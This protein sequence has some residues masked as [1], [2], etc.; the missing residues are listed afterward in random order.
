[1][2]ADKLSTGGASPSA[3]S[4]KRG[5]EKRKSPLTPYREKG[6]EKGKRENL[7]LIML[8]DTDAEVSE[9]VSVKGLSSAGKDIFSGAAYDFSSGSCR[10]VLPPRESAFVLFPVQ[11]R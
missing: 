11:F 6:K 10:V 9:T 8:N 1:M 4:K 3:E 7:L 2:N 5:G